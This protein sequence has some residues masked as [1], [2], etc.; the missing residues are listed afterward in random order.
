MLTV[1][2][3]DEYI[4]SSE[5]MPESNLR[6]K[7]EDHLLPWMLRQTSKRGIKLHCWQVIGDSSVWK[8][9]ETYN[10]NWEFSFEDWNGATQIGFDLGNPDVIK[11]ALDSTQEL[12]GEYPEIAGIHYDYIRYPGTSYTP[13]EY[14]AEQVTNVVSLAREIT[15][16]YEFTVAATMLKFNRAANARQDWPLWLD[17]GLIDRALVMNYSSL[18]EETDSYPQ[19]LA[20]LVPFAKDVVGSGIQLTKPGSIEN[21]GIEIEMT[22]QFGLD[23]AI[24][25]LTEMHNNNLE[26]VLRYLG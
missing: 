4:Y 18:E 22:K 21:I 9:V 3:S 20:D 14:T 24:F 11:A 10:S 15:E 6:T 1:D 2:D 26:V 12:L 13:T 25:S 19:L 7:D 5:I 8:N 23:V 17:T 16:G